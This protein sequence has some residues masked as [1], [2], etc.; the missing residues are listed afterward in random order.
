MHLLSNVQLLFLFMHLPSRTSSFKHWTSPF[1]EI[2]MALRQTKKTRH[3]NSYTLLPLQTLKALKLILSSYCET[4]HMGK[5]STG[6][7]L[8]LHQ[9]WCILEFCFVFFFL[10]QL[11][12]L[13]FWWCLV[14]STNTWYSPWLFWTLQITLFT[15]HG[16]K[17]KTLCYIFVDSSFVYVWV[18]KYIFAYLN[19]FFKNCILIFENWTR[20]PNFVDHCSFEFFA[21]KF[22]LNKWVF[23]FFIENKK[24]SLFSNDL[25]T[26]KLDSLFSDFWIVNKNDCVFSDSEFAKQRFCIFRFWIVKKKLNSKRI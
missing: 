10:C 2:L 22:L 25:I 24:D 20:N 6:R 12:T 9:N 17:G 1:K 7:N 14:F 26:N 8:E 13:C 19:F 18:C 11:L 3:R 16:I 15:G 23:R 5:K 4:M 21:I